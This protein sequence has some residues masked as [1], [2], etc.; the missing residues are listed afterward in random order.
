MLMGELFNERLHTLTATSSQ[1]SFS[2]VWD[3]NRKLT[4]SRETLTPT[5]PIAAGVTYPRCQGDTD[6][7][8]EGKLPAQ[9][10]YNNSFEEVGEED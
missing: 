2:E 4:K 9:H 7:R 3:V 5:H 1:N 8:V 6:D 10:I